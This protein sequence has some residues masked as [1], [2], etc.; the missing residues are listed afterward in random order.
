MSKEYCAS[1]SFSSEQTQGISAAKTDFQ[2]VASEPTDKKPLILM[3]E[4]H[5]ISNGEE[6]L[7][8]MVIHSILMLYGT[9]VFNLQVYFDFDVELD[10]YIL[11]FKPNPELEF[12]TQEITKQ[13][14]V[15]YL[16]EL[17]EVV[18]KIFGNHK[19]FEVNP[20]HCELKVDTKMDFLNLIVE[21]LS[22]R[23]TDI[24]RIK[25]PLFPEEPDIYAKA[26][27]QLSEI[28]EN[29]I[30]ADPTYAVTLLELSYPKFYPSLKSYLAASEYFSSQVNLQ[31][32]NLSTYAMLAKE[33]IKLEDKDD[34]RIKTGTT[35]PGY[36]IN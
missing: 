10:K 8:Y 20:Q 14:A 33:K 12:A 4:E 31:H 13:I 11:E 5:H 23:N 16:K 6:M 2:E 18:T 34:P 19:K 3:G 28:A 32:H 27:K 21:H 26:V 30:G 25:E 9:D 35:F 15:G 17:G 36:F 24:K 22:L 1:V 7:A 29:K